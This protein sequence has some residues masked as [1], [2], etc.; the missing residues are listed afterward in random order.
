MSRRAH[1]DGGQGVSHASGQ[2]RDFEFNLRELGG[3]LGDFGT[4]FPLAIGYIAINGLNPA[5]L[6]VMLGLT[7]IALGLIY[8]L[9]MPLQPKK[10]IAA[11]AISEGWSPS[12]ITASG[13]GMGLTWFF[14]VFTG[15]LRKLIEWTPTA[16]VRGIQLALG[17]TLGWQAIKMMAPTPLLGILAIVIV[18]LLRQNRYA[19]ASVVLIALGVGLAAWRGDL[20]GLRLAFTLPPLTIPRPADVWQAMVLAG[21]AQIPL[22]VTNAVMATAT[23]IRDYFPEKAVGER[24]LMLNMGVM[25][26]AAAFFGGMPM[27]HGSGGLVAQYYFGART[28]ATPI[29]EGVIEVLIGLF[30]SRSIADVMVAFPM[31]LI[32]G[33][34][35][36]VGIQLGLPTLKLRGWGLAVAVT[37][38]AVSAVTN[39]GIGFLA[40]LGLSALL[41][42]LCRRDLLPCPDLDADGYSRRERP[43]DDGAPLIEDQE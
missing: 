38:A 29:M 19:P 35:L 23:T 22:S 14:L 16:L 4:L 28:G 27:C 34:L 33:M 6:F 31:A 42:G 15:L 9:P 30:L 21:F 3:S 8:R 12:L 25:N 10:V 1:Q 32:G 39:I 5:G 43:S 40:G 37:T 13:F 36:L 18:L 26:T 7:N 41:R 24:K 20:R 17:L 2:H 11:V